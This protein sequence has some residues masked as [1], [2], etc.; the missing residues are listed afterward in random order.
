MQNLGDVAMLK[1][2]YNRIRKFFPE[3]QILILT[4]DPRL[5]LKEFHDVIPLNVS[6]KQAWFSAKLFP[7][8]FRIVP[9]KIRRK[10]EYFENFLTLNYPIITI[11]LKNKSSMIR[12]NSNEVRKFSDALRESNIVIVSGGG[13]INDYSKILAI[14]LLDELAIAKRLGKRTAIFGLGLGPISNNA[15]LKKIKNVFPSL[16]ICGLREGI[17]GP[18]ILKSLDVSLRNVVISGDD[19]IELALNSSETNPVQRFIGV[20]FRM[21]LRSQL[22]TDKLSVIK[23]ILI[24]LKERVNLELIALPVYIKNPGSDISS[25]RKFFGEGDLRISDPMKIKEPE[26]LIKLI[27]KC[28]I[29]ISGSYHSAVF[30]LSQGIPV[31]AIASTNYYLHKF[32]GLANQFHTGCEVVDLKSPTFA[33]EFNSSIQ[34]VLCI[35]EDQKKEMKSQ[36]NEQVKIS[37]DIYQRFLSLPLL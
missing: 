25:L 28:K 18:K 30:A 26:E 37:Y 9:I 5:V 15:I 35:T 20:N 32:V 8:P 31:V 34:E 13:L 19:A 2:A 14:E 12:G 22:E 21:S 23:E 11:W 36:A 17:E 16:D 33:Y 1:V 3:A 29:V 10:I 24:D 27:G 6:C 7:I 4:K